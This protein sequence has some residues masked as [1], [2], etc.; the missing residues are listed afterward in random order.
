MPIADSMFMYCE[1]PRGLSYFRGVSGTPGKDSGFLID[2]VRE[3]W[4]D[5]LH[6]YGDFVTS[7]VFSRHMAEKALN[8]LD[9]NDI[10]LKVWIDHGSADNCQNF[11]TPAIFSKGD[12]PK[13]RGYHTDLLAQ[14]GVFFCAGY[15]SDLIGQNGKRTYLAKS[16]P[17]PDVALSTV[18]KIH[19]RIYGKRLLRKK[20][21]KD[22]NLF[23]FFCR[24]RNGVL[25]P[26]VSTL[27]HQLSHGHVRK[28]IQA[29]GT[30]LL[31]QHLGSMQKRVD[32]FSGLDREARRALN[33]IAEQYRDK[34]I[35]V[36]S[37]SKILT[38][39]CL[40][41]NIDLKHTFDEDLLT[42][43]IVDK[44]SALRKFDKKDLANLS[45]RVENFHGKQIRLKHG[46]Y[47]LKNSEYDIFRDHGIVVKLYP[48]QH[49]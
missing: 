13:H 20:R 5:S 8:E 43:E 25:R 7:N 46:R 23:Y 21:I 18:K 17:Q 16:L 11:S 12:S 36:N 40:L 3:G 14:Y 27:S 32:G 34:V 28:L 38:Y 29:E 47:I 22:N 26:N 15:N 24:A 19:G 30:M 49:T 6:G 9:R 37:V 35:W 31:Y 1:R 48:D 44:N 2:A 33:N 10:K 42:I 45:F 39:S 41:E 4:I